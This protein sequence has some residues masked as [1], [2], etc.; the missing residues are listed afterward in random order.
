MIERAEE[1]LA[2]I[3]DH[4]SLEDH[5]SVPHRGCIKRLFGKCGQHLMD[6]VR[7]NAILLLPLILTRLHQKLQEVSSSLLNSEK[8]LKLV[9]SSNYSLELQ[10][11]SSIKD[12]AY[13]S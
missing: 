1:L 9:S 10:M 7:E 3:D 4:C 11:S 2:K 6:S 5:F 8:E 13:T 12:D